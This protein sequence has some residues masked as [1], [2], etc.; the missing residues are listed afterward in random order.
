M[1]RERHFCMIEEGTPS[2]FLLKVNAKYHE[3]FEAGCPI[4]EVQYQTTS[5][6]I[7]AEFSY[8]TNYYAFFTFYSE[9]SA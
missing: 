9:D 7:E 5:Q 2:N 1:N 6:V 8:S 4:I 3:L